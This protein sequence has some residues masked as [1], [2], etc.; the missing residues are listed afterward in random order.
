MASLAFSFHMI[1]YWLF[2]NLISMRLYRN[3]WRHMTL[4]RRLYGYT[5]TLFFHLKD[6]I[7]AL[8]R[9]LLYT[10]WW[11]IVCSTNKNVGLKL[12][13]SCVFTIWDCL[14]H[15]HIFTPSSFSLNLLYL[16][17]YLSVFHLNMFNYNF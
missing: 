6:T 15:L 17:E 9:V 2:I 12:S 8:V 16:Y 10:R 5:S 4:S 1:P 7:Y 3:Q 13:S 11:V 14:C